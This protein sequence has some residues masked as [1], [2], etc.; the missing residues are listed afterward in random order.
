MAEFRFT[1]NEEAALKEQLD[2]W[3]KILNWYIAPI[4]YGA[5]FSAIP[6]KGYR[7][8]IGWLAVFVIASAYIVARE[9]F[10]A[11]LSDL[12]SKDKTYREEI[13]YR[14]VVS[15][16]FGWP[17]IIKHFGLYF[18]SVVSLAIILSGLLERLGL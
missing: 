8:I 10:P 9:K 11:I 5:S 15:Y 2:H 17:G 18:F 14:G 4:V 16:Y 6:A 13:I 1:K 7:E 12:K 3:K